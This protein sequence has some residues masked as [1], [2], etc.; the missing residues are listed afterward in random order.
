MQTYQR[1]IHTRASCRNHDRHPFTYCSV[2][3]SM[4]TTS[5]KSI[6]KCTWACRI[7]HAIFAPGHKPK[8]YDV[9]QFSLARSREVDQLNAEER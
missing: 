8:D 2:T 5:E 9:D 3:G 4:L 7:E 6:R 1:A